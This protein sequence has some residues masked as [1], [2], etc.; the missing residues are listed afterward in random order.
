MASSSWPTV[1]GS[2]VVNDDQWELMCSALSP[3]GVVGSHTDTSVVYG[4]STGRQVKIRSGKLA[5]V[6]GGGWHS[7]ASDITKSIAANASGSTRTDLVVLRRSRTTWAV[8]EEIV[9]GTPGAGV[10]ALTRNAKGGGTGVWEIP[11]ASVTVVNGAVTIASGDVTNM[12]WY[13]R[14][15]GVSTLST[16]SLQP[17]V[18]DYNM[19][20]HHD[21]GNEWV[22]V[23]GSWRVHGLWRS[24]QLLTGSAAS[25]NFTGIPTYLR[26][27]QLVC[28]ARGD[29]AS[30]LTGFCLRVGGDTGNVYLW[31]Q[32]F[33]QNGGSPGNAQFAAV[34]SALFGYCP[35]ASYP[36][37]MWGSAEVTWP[38]WDRTTRALIGMCR[39][40][41]MD[42][43]SNLI[44]NTGVVIYAG[45]NTRNSLLIKPDAGNFIAGSQFLLEGRE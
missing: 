21:T 38:D 3:D 30:G 45:S 33:A 42:T 32:M 14:G 27:V 1:A 22:P 34:S 40:G 35:A 20:H 36:A 4:D 29:T 7:G 24:S 8:T 37:A 25:V 13:I 17:P 5:Q 43:V 19:L 28:N 18:A 39:G 31:A 23:S 2:R 10:P 9:Q 26:K 16:N 41:N 15:G 6:A 11:L 12:T 44:I